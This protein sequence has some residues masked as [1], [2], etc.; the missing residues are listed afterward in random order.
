MLQSAA[1]IRR[2]MHRRIY[3]LIAM[4]P[5]LSPYFCLPEVLF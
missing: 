4:A 1:L 2:L 3:D 5:N